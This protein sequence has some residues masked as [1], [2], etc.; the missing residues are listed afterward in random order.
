MED[1][2]LITQDELAA[3]LRVPKGWVV[4]AVTAREIPFTR[5]GRHVRFSRENVRAIHEQGFEP[6]IN[7]AA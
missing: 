1:L 5:V 4:K 2:E 7:R 3:L 6:A